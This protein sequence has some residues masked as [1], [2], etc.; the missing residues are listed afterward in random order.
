VEALVG[1]IGS[2]NQIMANLVPETIISTQS[3][4]TR[5][6]LLL[7][8]AHSVVFGTHYLL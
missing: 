6:K 2:E 4:A 8:D 7:N 5:A 3:S 1:Q